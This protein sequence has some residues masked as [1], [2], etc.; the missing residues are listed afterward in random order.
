MKSAGDRDHQSPEP[1]TVKGTA[2]DAVRAG[3]SPHSKRISDMMLI[4]CWCEIAGRGEW[5]LS[6]LLEDQQVEL[7]GWSRG[8]HSDGSPIMGYLIWHKMIQER[9]INLRLND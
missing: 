1:R 3:L 9:K 8:G 5:F 4:N 6:D 7:R 2:G